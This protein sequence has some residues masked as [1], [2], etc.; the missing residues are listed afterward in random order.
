MVLEG[1]KGVMKRNAAGSSARGV[2][3]LTARDVEILRWIGRVRFATCEQVAARFE[4][5]SKV[6]YKRL[7]VLIGNGFVRRVPMLHNQPGAHHI[8]KAG[9]RMLGVGDMP[10]PTVGLQSFLHDQAVV[11]EQISLEASG[12]E[13]LTEREMRAAE[14]TLG[15]QYVVHVPP[16]LS[17]GASTHRPDLAFRVNSASPWHAVEVELAAKSE[18]R[19]LAILGAYRADAQYAA[20]VYCVRDVRLIDRVRSVGLDVD[21]GDR[22]KVVVAQERVAA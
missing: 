2:R 7:A 19:L 20:V 8:T 4:M 15:E 12:A 14:R 5:Y 17:T 3:A 9:M 13:V 16:H 11:W 1:G 18:A 21:L 22:L 6:A 10:V